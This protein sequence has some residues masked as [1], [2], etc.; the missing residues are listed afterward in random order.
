LPK[1]L[2]FSRQLSNFTKIRSLN[3]PRAAS[4]PDNDIFSCFLVI[5]L[6][7]LTKT[8]PL[9]S[10]HGRCPGPSQR[11]HPLC[12]P[13]VRGKMFRCLINYTTSCKCFWRISFVGCI[14]RTLS[15]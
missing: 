9:D 14:T 2:T 8:G 7:I 3:A 6:H 10:P 11:S 5:Y 12:S 15:A 13:L 4:Y 1:F